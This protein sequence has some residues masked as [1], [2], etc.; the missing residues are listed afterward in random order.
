LLLLLLWLL[1]FNSPMPAFHHHPQLLLLL[2][3]PLRPT[4]TLLLSRMQ[5]LGPEPPRGGT[6]I[7]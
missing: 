1:P 5:L 4:S 2:L 7:Y 6:D 3:L